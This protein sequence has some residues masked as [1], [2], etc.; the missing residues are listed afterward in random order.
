MKKVILIFVIS[1]FGC[2]FLNA[3]PFDPN[4]TVTVYVHGFNNGGYKRKATYGDDKY[5]SF[6]ESIPSFIALPTTNK[7]ED[8]NKPNVVATT[9]Y[10]G[11]KPPAYYTA[12]D[13]EDIEDITAQYGG[14]IPR[15]AMIMAKYAK[16][17]L[18]RTGAKQVNFVSGSMGALVTRWLIEKNYENLAAD[19]KIARWLTL[20]GVVGGNYAASNDFFMKIWD[21]VDEPSIDVEHMSYNWINNNLHNPHRNSDS[22]YFKDILIGHETSTKDDALS[23]ALTTLLILN[24]QYMPNDGFQ[25][26]YDTYFNR[27]SDESK[28]M[29]Y[30]PTHSYF[31]VNHLGIKTARGAWVQI[32]SF[33]L[34]NKRVEI[35]LQKAAVYDL[36]EKNHWYAKFLPAEVVFESEFFSP[37]AKKRWD[38]E[39]AISQRL[40]GGAV[41]PVYKYHQT[42][43]KTVNQPL[44]NDFV[45][46]NEKELELKLSATEI[47]ADERYG[48]FESLK[49]RKYENIDTIN[50]NVPLKDGVYTFK[51]ETIEVTLSVKIINYPFKLL[52]ENGVNGI[53]DGEL[54]KIIKRLYSIVL[55]REASKGEIK[56]WTGYLKDHPGD[57]YTLSKK[58]LLSKENESKDLSIDEFIALS[59]ETVFGYSA[60]LEQIRVWR[61]SFERG[62]TDKNRFLDDLLSND[63]AR[64]LIDE[65]IGKEGGISE[66]AV[67]ERGRL[68]HYEKVMSKNSTYLKDFFKDML[69]SHPELTV[70]KI[71]GV[72]AYKIIYTTVNA[73]KE[74]V[75]ASGLLTLPKDA[76]EP[77]DLVSDQHG[78]KFGNFDVPSTHDPLGSVGTLISATKGYAVSMPDYIG[79]GKS[80]KYFHPYLIKEPIANSI[81]DMLFAVKEFLD[82]RGI[83]QSGKL[84]LSGYSE[85]GYATMAAL[86]EIEKNYKD[87][88]QVTAGAPMA[89]SYDMKTTA[90][91]VLNQKEY[92]Y[93]NLPAFVLYS[94]NHYYN[95][96]RL[97]EI[98]KD[99][100]ADEL[101]NFFKEKAKGNMLH[102]DLPAKREKMYQD[103]FIEDYLNGGEED[104]K[105]V[106]VENSIIDWKPT[107]KMRLY[108]CE[109][110][111]VVPVVNSQNAYKSF[112]DKGS[113][114]VELVTKEGGGHGECS[115]PFYIDAYEW[116]DTLR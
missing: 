27:L 109:G 57:I 53:E 80:L 47:D 36:H 51:G 1:L 96:N 98:F 25:V 62:Y 89:G 32:A 90:D 22:P 7:E 55:D 8:K 48:I 65:I 100:Y 34:S 4:K 67:L 78:T 18:K 12:K 81:I 107:M 19:K 15:Y 71:R 93:P 6:F 99:P 112:I 21:E 41:V 102:I 106:L 87:E 54:E 43:E 44:F 9:D 31:H 76:S 20:E 39:D 38:I 28:F 40:V 101:D 5:E 3:Q 50:V 2:L 84:F 14:G 94:Y 114:S 45:F 82:K 110:D 115:I 111:K 17:L 60:N 70:D 116:F 23:H 11:D 75:N 16:H 113:N 103:R 105:N 97:H 64:K 24:G 46:P 104:L 13:I 95:W 52:G 29:G 37:Y 83:K 73:N 69:S 74:K 108:H 58:F 59:Y 42:G 63:D 30:M 10:Y 35:T 66:N 77:L 86:E 88:L 56:Y 85:G 91:M 72:E 49:N 33:L 26:A 68:V 92:D 61:D 79:Y